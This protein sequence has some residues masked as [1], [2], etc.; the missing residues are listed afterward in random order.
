LPSTGATRPWVRTAN[1]GAFVSS[2]LRRS[3]K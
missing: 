1:S 3:L 2:S